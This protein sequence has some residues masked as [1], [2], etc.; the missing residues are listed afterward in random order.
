MTDANDGRH[1]SGD[2]DVGIGDPDVAA[3][4]ILADV[5]VMTLVIVANS[6]V[7]KFWPNASLVHRCCLRVHFTFFTGSG[8]VEVTCL[9]HS[10]SIESI[11][12]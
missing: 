2:I 7:T 10:F 12:L 9:N 6:L 8:F 3:I 4:D 1:M 5:A 11:K